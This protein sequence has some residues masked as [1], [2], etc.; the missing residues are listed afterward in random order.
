M[1]GLSLIVQQDSMLH[2][3]LESFIFFTKDLTATKI[4]IL[5]RSDVIIL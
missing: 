2:V 5:N 3:K 4:V 1:S